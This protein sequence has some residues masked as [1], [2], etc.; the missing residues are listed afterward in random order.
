MARPRKLIKYDWYLL[1]NFFSWVF[2]CD[3]IAFI[4]ILL[5]GQVSLAI[6]PPIRDWYF[7]GVMSIF[8]L[9]GVLLFR[10][11][12]KRWTLGSQKE[13]KNLRGTNE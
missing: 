9:I 3:G 11:R 13:M 12:F 4:L 6:K 2:L 8:G 1:W 5:V 7:L 10:R